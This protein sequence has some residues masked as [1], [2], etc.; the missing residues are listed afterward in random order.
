MSR[1]RALIVCLVVLAAP[2]ACARHRAAGDPEKGRRAF[3]EFKCNACHDVVGETLPPASVTPAVSLGGRML[4]PPSDEK[5]RT[6][7]TMPSSHFAVGYPQEQIT[8]GGH[9]RMP[10]YS[11]VLTPDQVNDLV[12]YLGTR[13]QRGLPSATH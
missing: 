13:Y 12:A 1:Q 4:L 11:K 3:V 5:L 7:I 8:K 6:D 10:D 2:V 9:S